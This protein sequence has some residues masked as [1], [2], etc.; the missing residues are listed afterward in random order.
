MMMPV[1]YAQSRFHLSVMLAALLCFAPAL[2]AQE[3]PDSSEWIEK[4]PTPLS[5]TDVSRFANFQENRSSA[6]EEAMKGGEAADR[7][8]LE[9]ILAG[10]PQAI[11]DK[12]LKGEWRCRT[13]KLG[14]ILPLVVYGAFKCRIFEEKGALILQ[15]TSGSQRTRGGL[16]RISPDRFAYIGASTVN[17][18]PVRKY[19]DA[20]QEDEVALLVKVGPARLRLE[21]PAPHYES[22]F[23]IIEFVR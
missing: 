6:I 11:A 22:H 13:V 21:F 9:K 14:G 23:D 12:D 1:R 15:K 2:A 5:L 10:K 19:G 3:T 16:Y 18:D 7:A 4:L 8:S 17:D 20:A